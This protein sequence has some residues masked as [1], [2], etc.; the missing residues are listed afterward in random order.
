MVGILLSISRDRG[1]LEDDEDEDDDLPL[2][3]L[4]L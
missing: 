1:Q 2:G 3:K 4:S